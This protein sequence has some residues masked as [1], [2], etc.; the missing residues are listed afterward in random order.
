[1]II[2][3]A[4]D[5][6]S[7]GPRHSHFQGQP[8]C[9]KQNSFYYW[10][11]RGDFSPGFFDRAFLPLA[12]ADDAPAQ[13]S[14]IDSHDAT[15]M[16]K[17]IADA[18]RK[19]YEPLK[20]V[21][22]TFEETVIS[23]GLKI[24]PAPFAAPAKENGAAPAKNGGVGTL[25]VDVQP[26]FAMRNEFSIKGDKLLSKQIARQSDQWSE[27]E[28]VG[29]RGDIWTILTLRW[30]GTNQPRA[31]SGRGDQMGGHGP[32]DPSNFGWE[33]DHYNLFDNLKRSKIIEVVSRQPHFTIRTEVVDPVEN[34]YQKGQRFTL[35]FDPAR[36]YL[37]VSMIRYDD[38]GSINVLTEYTYDE[39]IPGRS[40][41]LH[42]MM[43][44]F[45]LNLDGKTTTSP[46]SNQWSQM[47]TNRLV[48]NLKVNGEISDDT[49]DLKIPDGTDAVDVTKRK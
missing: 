35:T 1:M 20:S 10:S 12:T 2:W 21:Q 32:F 23:P 29:R 17:Q 22:G 34:H 13:K 30:P 39:V 9:E 33:N 18:I 15:E 31:F 26:A 5:T 37:P 25:S 40:W 46:S 36:N 38:K 6:T 4:I 14:A 47:A 41:Y 28:I 24:E 7:I 16:L 42:E 3:M 11:Q 48:G 43:R 8:S 45:F 44:K 27:N 49:F 19:N